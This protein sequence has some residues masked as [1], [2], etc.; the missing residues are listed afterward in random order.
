MP[1][2][3]KPPIV[4]APDIRTLQRLIGQVR[5]DSR[6]SEQDKTRAVCALSEI[7]EILAKAQARGPIPTVS[8]K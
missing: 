5:E 4:Y 1:A 3:A 6:V 7:T 8:A 2:K